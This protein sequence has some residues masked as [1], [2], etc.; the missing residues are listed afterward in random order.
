MQLQ[1]K[2]PLPLDGECLTENVIYQASVE[3]PTGN[4]EETYVGLTADTFKLCFANHKKSF[5]H[6]NYSTE[7]TL[8]SY[9]WKLK[10]ENVDYSISWKVIDRG[11]PFSP[12][13]GNCQLCTKEKFIIIFNPEISTLNRRDELGSACRHKARLLLKNI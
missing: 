2:Q 11:R 12:I 7:S 4:V 1:K 8:S 10:K 3:L 13:Y 5:K 6:E 9:V